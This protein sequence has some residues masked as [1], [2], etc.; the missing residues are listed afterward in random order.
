VNV[1]APLRKY[2]FLWSSLILSADTVVDGQMQNREYILQKKRT[3]YVQDCI[4]TGL[5]GS[6]KR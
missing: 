6:Y 4:N 3:E 2:L 5:Q 1:S